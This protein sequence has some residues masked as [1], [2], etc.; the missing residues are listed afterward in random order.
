MKKVSVVLLFVAAAMCLSLT[1]CDGGGSVSGGKSPSDIEMGMWKLVQKGNY[2]K[3]INYW[4]ENSADEDAQG[5]SKDQIKAMSSMFSE[6][7]KQ[8]MDEKG[9]L[10]DVKIESETISEDGMT[11]RVEVLLI[12]G[13]GTTEEQTSEYIK[14]D[15]KWKMNNSMK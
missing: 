15:S 5:A 13:D 4:M 3:A 1:S 8:S 12:Y 7:M 14:V 10:K 2:Q 6:K 11:A 9:G